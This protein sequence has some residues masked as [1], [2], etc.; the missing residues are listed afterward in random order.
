MSIV[1]AVPPVC[2]PPLRARLE[3]RGWRR[4]KHRNLRTDVCGRLLL[5]CA[6]R[7]STSEV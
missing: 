4:A 6:L 7:R 3:M 2:I 1:L 5:L